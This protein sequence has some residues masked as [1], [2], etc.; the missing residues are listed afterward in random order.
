MTNDNNGLELGAPSTSKDSGLRSTRSVS[1][2]TS[3][4]KTAIT[5]QFH[6][7]NYQVSERKGNLKIKLDG[8]WSEF[9]ERS[10]NR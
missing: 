3:P 5:R 8:K 6:E 7:T 9:K 1:A 4:Y 2:P 10:S